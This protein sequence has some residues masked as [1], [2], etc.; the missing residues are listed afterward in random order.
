[1][2]NSQ[3]FT[4]IEM[5]VVVALIALLMVG[6]TNL[7]LA[8]LRGGGKANAIST[9]REN[10]GVALERMERHI[11]YARVVACSENSSIKVANIST[12]EELTYAHNAGS[13]SITEGYPGSITSITGSSVVVRNFRLACP[14]TSDDLFAPDIVRI[15]FEV[16]H[17]QNT[18]VSEFF[19]TSIVLRNT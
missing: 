11:R 18:S 17:S 6:V 13:G 14:D 9:V 15:S 5:L 4:L 1:M 16:Q 3:G 12:G 19:Q 2:K 7:M 10:G 8:T